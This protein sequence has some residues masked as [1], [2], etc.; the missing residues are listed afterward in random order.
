MRINRILIVVG[1]LLF[2]VAALAQNL[3]LD[4]CLTLALQNNA[5]VK[6]ASLDVEAAKAVKQ[7]AFT[8]Y[9][10]QISVIAGGY[11]A[12]NPI[13]EYGIDDIEN[14]GIRDL[15]NV[16]YNEFGSALGFSNSISLFEHGLA[17]GATAVQPVFMGGR[18]VN[19]N[20]LAS[21]G[22]QAAELQTQLAQQEVLLQT[23]ESYWLVISLQEKEKTIQQAQML[24]DTLFKD[25]TTAFDA[26]VILKNDVLKVTLKRNELESNRLKLE[27]GLALAKSA[28][29]QSIGV[30]YDEQL[31]LIDTLDGSYSEPA[32][33]YQEASS[34]ASARRENQL[35]A[36]NV[37]AEQLK[38]KM[39]VGEALPQILFGVG[40]TYG[41]LV[42]NKTAYNGLA[43]AT[44]SVPITA[45]WETAHKLK[46]NEVK[47]AQAKNNYDDLT[48]K[49]SLQITQ[50][51]NDLDES[52]RQIAIAKETVEAAREN[53]KIA[54][55]NFHSGII[56]VSEY[57]EAQTIF[58]QAEDQYSDAQI[59]YKIKL[60]RYKMLTS[61]SL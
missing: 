53:M 23:E 61:K 7:Q 14:S 27:N 15:L 28:L 13:L 26:G 25:V 56:P 40:C 58:R 37:K 11:H 10:P 59:A 8:K 54:G 42:T 12:Q 20:R 35:L 24:L 51:W 22:V 50:S 39:T 44:L 34:A 6:N 4:S 5:K 30:K 49:M 17:V 60:S 46:A 41:N 47:M 31:L 52:Y 1:L 21:L 43:F 48:E 55:D 16:F 3:S 36:L 57:L 18:I 19:G 32:S 45:W 9:F 33:V 29:C 38:R 2:S